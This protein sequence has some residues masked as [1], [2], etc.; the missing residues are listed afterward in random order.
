MWGLLV[1]PVVFYGLS[2]Y[3]FG[4]AW[5]YARE[6][7]ATKAKTPVSDQWAKAPRRNAWLCVLYG[8]LFAVFF[9][10]SMW[11]YFSLPPQLTGWPLL[12]A[13]LGCL[14]AV[15]VGGILMGRLKHN[16][17]TSGKSG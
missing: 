1:L 7:Q 5:R 17:F 6:Y 3:L 12:L 13:L 15:V 9:L 10:I 2:L 8:S 14:A 11:A 4:S 16:R